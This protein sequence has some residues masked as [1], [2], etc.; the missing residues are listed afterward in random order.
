MNRRTFLKSTLA[1]GAFTIVPRHVLGGTGFTAPSD[2]L[3]KAVIGV[4]G[5]GR[6][7]LRYA[8]AKLLAVCDVDALHLKE[9][10]EIGGKDV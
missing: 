4:G 6:G 1:A 9:A 8:G 5:M 2:H 10:L 3:T 7:H